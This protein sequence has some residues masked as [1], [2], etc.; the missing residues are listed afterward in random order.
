MLEIWR[1]AAVLPNVVAVCMA[2]WIRA[3]CHCHHHCGCMAWWNRGG[4]TFLGQRSQLPRSIDMSGFISCA[5]T[6]V[7]SGGDTTG[8]LR[9]DSWEENDVVLWGVGLTDSCKY[10]IHVAEYASLQADGNHILSHLEQIQQM[11][12]H[13]DLT[14]VLWFERN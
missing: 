4:G 9:H 3:I 14:F 13:C 5:S 11:D 8:R 10:C 6:N 2:I 12:H 1:P 7:Q